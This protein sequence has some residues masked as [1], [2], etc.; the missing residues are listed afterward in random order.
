MSGPDSNKPNKKRSFQLTDVLS[1][2]D[3]GTAGKDTTP[4]VPVITAEEERPTVAAAGYS[5]DS[6]LVAKLLADI[7]QK[8]TEIMRLNAELMQ[9][10]FDIKEKDYRMS[11]LALSEAGKD[12]QILELKASLISLKNEVQKLKAEPATIPAQIKA[13]ETQVSDEP[14]VVEAVKVPE[15][16]SETPPL[17]ITRIV[18]AAR[19]ESSKPIR[20]EYTLKEDVKEEE[21]VATI[22]KRLIKARKDDAEESEAEGSSP[23]LRSAKLYDL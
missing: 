1:I 22:F 20:E 10:K 15:P 13:V 3:E 2:L 4:V 12:A 7:D 11:G 19:S 5:Q 21:D 23:K 9:L 17:Q 6:A 8:N 18:E 14:K 16:A